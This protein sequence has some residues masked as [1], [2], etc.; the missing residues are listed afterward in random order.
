MSRRGD[1]GLLPLITWG[2]KFLSEQANVNKWCCARISGRDMSRPYKSMFEIKV[3]DSLA[4]MVCYRYDQL[5]WSAAGGWK[6]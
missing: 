4:E 2:E 3:N 6:R 5:C 1:G